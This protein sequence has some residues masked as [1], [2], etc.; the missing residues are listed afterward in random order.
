MEECSKHQIELAEEKEKLVFICPKMPDE[1][2]KI[3][4]TNIIPKEQTYEFVE[5][6]KASTLIKLR[7]VTQH[8]GIY[9]A[10]IKGGKN[11]Q[12]TVNSKQSEEIKEKIF[13]EVDS[14]F[15]SD[16]YFV[17]WMISVNG[18][19]RRFFPTVKTG[20]SVTRETRISSD[21]IINLIIDL[22]TNDVDAFIAIM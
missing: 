17:G 18:E 21:E 8:F 9:S 2:I 20:A 16:S 7:A 5:S 10:D 1:K 11:V 4:L 13:E 3:Q 22:N 19:K 15:R 14:I 12:Y 6:M